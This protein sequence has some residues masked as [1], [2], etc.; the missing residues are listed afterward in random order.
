MKFYY[1]N[2]TH[3]DREWY[4][5][6]QEFRKYLI[7]TVKVLINNFENVPDY[8]RFTLDG[9]TVCLEDIEEIRPDLAAK[10]DNFIRQG[11]LNIG[12][13]YAMPDEFLVSGEAIIRNWQTAQKIAAKHGTE[14]WNVCYICDIFGH[15]SQFPQMIKKFG[16][17]GAV[18]WRGVDSKIKAYCFWDSPDGSRIKLIRQA[19]DCGYANFTLKVLNWANIPLDETEF[20]VGF[21]KWIENNRELYDNGHFI[22]SDAYDHSMP[23]S[24]INDIF[25]W[26]KELYPDA[27]IIHSDYRDVFANEYNRELQSVSGEL[28]CPCDVP[29]NAAWQISAT[30]SSRYDLKYG[31]DRLQ[32]ALEKSLEPQL[33]YL[34]LAGNKDVNYLLDFAWKNL[35]KNHAHDSICGCSIDSVH[36]AMLSR[37][38]DI[39]QLNRLMTE[40][41]LSADRKKLTGHSIVDDA[42]IHHRTREPIHAECAADGN[43]TLRINNP[44]PFAVNKLHEVDIYFPA[45]EEYPKKMAEPFGYE[46]I[47]CFKLFDRDHRE[48]PYTIRK[49]KRNSNRSFF[50]Q[51]LRRYDIYTIAFAAELPPSSWSSFLLEASKNPVRYFDSLISGNN[52]AENG[53]IRLEVNSDGTFCVTD[54]RNNRKYDNQNNYFIDREIGD[55]WN[56]VRPIGNARICGTSNAQIR[57][58]CDSPSFAEFEITRTYDIPEELHFD[59]SI[60]ERYHGISESSQI[61]QLKIVSKVG[62]DSFSNQL[63][64]HTAICNDISDYRLQLLVPSGIEGNYFANQMFYFKER[65]AGRTT[66]KASQSLMESEVIEKNFNGI[67]GKSDINGGIA[68][69]SEAGLHEAGALDGM[70]DHPLVITLYR[71]FRRVFQTDGQ[72]DGQLHKNLEFNYRLVC[73]DRKADYAALHKL[74]LEQQTRFANYLVKSSAVLPE[75]TDCSWITLSENA[76]FSALKPAADGSN[77]AILRFFNPSTS[78]IQSSVTLA[79]PAII[80]QCMLNETAETMIAKGNFATISVHPQEIVTLKITKLD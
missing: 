50:R 10:L 17:D 13:W 69:I 73:F 75:H 4:Q 33:S 18:L 12:P 52:S 16:F 74:Q 48:I 66:G 27:E 59:G 7:D 24:G 14:C 80:E 26:I 28:I 45:V 61:K 32:N 15:T 6:F 1:F 21:A 31:N 54:L 44:L 77:S 5:G 25:K 35:I 78:E 47:N 2:S 3:W 65:P 9:Q 67:I 53:T 49:I 43:Y 58:S 70:K 79:F 19:P 20:K 41:L 8:N 60:E 51:D 37:F 57:I 22:L 23:T 71:A 30:L 36:R 76:A 29:P 42:R 55:G 46:F 72:I 34:T 11:K 40:E 38:E 56:H 62:I 64:V 63:H 68:F 39:E